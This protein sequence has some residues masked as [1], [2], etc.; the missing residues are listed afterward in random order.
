MATEIQDQHGYEVDPV[1][2]SGAGSGALPVTDSSIRSGSVGRAYDAAEGLPK[3]PRAFMPIESASSPIRVVGG[4]SGIVGRRDG[5][6]GAA[7]VSVCVGGRLIT[8]ACGPMLTISATG[9]ATFVTGR[10]SSE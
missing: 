6:A 8:T 2:P 4:A 7:A 3:P 5:S 9:T 1:P 10:S